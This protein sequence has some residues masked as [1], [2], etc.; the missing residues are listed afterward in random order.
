M[1]VSKQSNRS[2]TLMLELDRQTNIMDTD[3]TR[4]AQT[5]RWFNFCMFGHMPSQ[6][7]SPAAKLNIEFSVSVDG[8][9]RIMHAKD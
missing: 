5:E 1:V 9:K 3:G 2:T 6:L 4:S 8:L 7:V